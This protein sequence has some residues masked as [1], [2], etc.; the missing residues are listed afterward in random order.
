MK[1]LQW[2]RHPFPNLLYLEWLFLGMSFVTVFSNFPISSN[3]TYTG[4]IVLSLLQNSPWQIRAGVVVILLF[5]GISGLC[6]PKGSW[7]WIYISI[8]FGLSWLA[9]L[10]CL[11]KELNVVLVSRF[12]AFLLIVVVIRSYLIFSGISRQLLLITAYI[13]FQLFI[14]YFLVNYMPNL[15]IKEIIGL[16]LYPSFIFGAWMFLFL[17]LVH[18]L[19]AERQSR[20]ELAE[21]HRQL[22]R[23]AQLIE[24]Q[25]ILRER[26][27][28]A[29]EIH[30]AVGH[31]LAT[32]SIQLENARVLLEQDVK[33]SGYYLD[34]AR[35]LGDIAI[36]DM[37]RSL[38]ILSTDPLGNESF[39]TAFSRLLNNFQQST[40]IQLDHHLNLEINLSTE[41]AIAL[42]RIAQEALTNIIKHSQ[43]TQV[44]INLYQTNNYIILEI[45]DN[46]I[47]FNPE[48]NLAGFG[49]QGMRDRTEALGGKLE[50]ISQQSQ[51]CNIIVKIR[52]YLHE[53][54]S[55]IS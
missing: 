16:M 18:T 31:C 41:I 43:A 1:S 24:G 15:L 27:Y 4:I 46:G 20:Q 10:L 5:I 47:G 23:Y 12:I 21:S 32:Q 55:S 19:I 30:D 44:Y 22:Q 2:Q 53:N 14:I 36:R 49:L 50:I 6:L 38:S 7:C 3:P 40:P 35:E 34:K 25:A 9:S 33:K 42:Y 17:I 48:D 54:S 39:T 51:G 52:E 37:Q 45:Q 29:R 11:G 28:I 26:T 13:S 8:Q